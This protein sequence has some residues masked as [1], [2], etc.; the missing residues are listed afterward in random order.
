MDL[1]PLALRP[2]NPPRRADASTLSPRT[3]Y[4]PPEGFQASS[5]AISVQEGES[6]PDSDSESSFDSDFGPNSS[7][8]SAK[9]GGYVMFHGMPVTR[10][11]RR[12]RRPTLR[13]SSSS[14]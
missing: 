10:S 2:V 6:D 13:R 9:G 11:R 1:G 4:S 5:G 8:D 12:G 3:I 7:D 14:E